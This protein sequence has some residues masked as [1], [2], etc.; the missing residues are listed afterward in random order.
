MEVLEQGPGG[1]IERHGTR[2]VGGVAALRAAE[3][4]HMSRG[5]A[6]WKCHRIRIPTSSFKRALLA[7]QLCAGLLT[8]NSALPQEFAFASTPHCHNVSQE[9]YAAF[10]KLFL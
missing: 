9:R 4:V 6:D 10:A 8:C 5:R 3:V 2:P 1:V 7:L